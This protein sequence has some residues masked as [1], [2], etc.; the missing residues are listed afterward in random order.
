METLMSRG[1][2]PLVS[3]DRHK[4]HL[5]LSERPISGL[6]NGSGNHKNKKVQKFEAS[7]E[8]V[9]LK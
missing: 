3:I 5:N 1:E 6:V 2:K 4:R 9:V 7:V 8:W